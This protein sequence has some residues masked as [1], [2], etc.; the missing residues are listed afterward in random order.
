[1]AEALAFR[2]DLA[3][4]PGSRA[5]SRRRP[6]LKRRRRARPAGC[7]SSLLAE[8]SAVLDLRARDRSQLVELLALEDLELIELLGGR[9]RQALRRGPPQAPAHGPGC[10]RASRRL[11]PP[12]AVSHGGCEPRARR[13]CSTPRETAGLLRE[14]D[15]HPTVALLGTTRPSDYGVEMAHSLAHSLACSGVAGRH[16]ARRRHRASRPRRGAS[17]PGAAPW[18]SAAA[19]SRP[20]DDRRARARP[21]EPSGR[22]LPRRRA[23]AGLPGTALGTARSRTHRRSSSATWCWWWRPSPTQELFG[24]ELAR[25]SGAR[26]AAVPGRATAPLAR[27][28]A[29]AAAERR[30]ARSLAEDVLALL[31]LPAGRSSARCTGG[32]ALPV[33]LAR[34]LDRVG[35]GQE[36]PEQLLA[37]ADRERDPVRARRARAD[38]PGASHLR[39]PLHR[40]RLP[41]E[42]M[43]GEKSGCPR[44]PSTRRNRSFSP[45]NDLKPSLGDTDEGAMRNL[46]ALTHFDRRSSTVLAGV[47]VVIALVCGGAVEAAGTSAASAGTTRQQHP[48]SGSGIAG[49]NSYRPFV[50]VKR[51]APEELNREGRGSEAHAPALYRPRRA[52]AEAR[53]ALLARHT[54]VRYA[55]NRDAS[56]SASEL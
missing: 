26:I 50:P 55:G 42:W 7:R 12:P 43:K 48:R 35:S 45:R 4:E 24:V 16:P 47:F 29:R 14:S 27:G 49:G 6:G 46:R 18:C 25:A 34:L 33:R 41:E 10:S 39:R 31:G 37:G 38:G 23:A 53:R 30:V 32:Q 40:H 56:S 13:G 15:R 54:R 28:P 52:F 11:R 3:Y 22:Q 9:R 21:T 51:D 44:M 1:M 19:A 17:R 5:P 8:L 20:P 2:P 36:T